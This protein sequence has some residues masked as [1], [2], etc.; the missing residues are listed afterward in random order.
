[1]IMRVFC[2]QVV[3][4]IRGATDHPFDV[5]ATRKL[6]KLLDDVFCV[7]SGQPAVRSSL[8][9]K[10]MLAQRLDGIEQE[11]QQIPPNSSARGIVP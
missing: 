1:M 6:K 11:A 5:T 8:C 3:L 10:Q 7:L 9:Q 2:T 4:D